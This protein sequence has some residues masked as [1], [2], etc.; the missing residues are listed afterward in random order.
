[1]QATHLTDLDIQLISNYFDSLKKNN[2]DFGCLSVIGFCFRTLIAFVFVVIAFSVISAP[3]IIIVR[4]KSSIFALPN[5]FG[6]KTGQF[7]VFV[8]T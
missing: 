2:Q 4:I 6:Y 7:F 1:M 5:C 8:E 3:K